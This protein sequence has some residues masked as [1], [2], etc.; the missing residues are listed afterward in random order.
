MKKI[1][2]TLVFLFLLSR[3]TSI[4]TGQDASQGEL[5]INARVTQNTLGTCRPYTDEELKKIPL[6]MRQKEFCKSNT[7][8]YTMQV[9]VDGIKIT[10]KTIQPQSSRGDHPLHFEEKISLEKQNHQVALSLLPPEGID[11]PSYRFVESIPIEP[12]RIVFVTLNEDSETFEI[13]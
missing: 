11:L 13:Q 1:L 2:P 12:G 10:E 8:S 6:H 5:R 4:W 9:I 7:Y 3:L